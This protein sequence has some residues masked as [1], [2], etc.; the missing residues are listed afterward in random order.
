MKEFPTHSGEKPVKSTV[1]VILVALVASAILWA[2][3]NQIEGDEAPALSMEASGT[4][5][6][7]EPV[8]AGNPERN[9][10]D[11]YLQVAPDGSVFLSWTEQEPKHEREGLTTCQ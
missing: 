6:L 7:N 1:Q 8:A 4:L 2:G 11:P 3:C 9:P 5:S 10:A